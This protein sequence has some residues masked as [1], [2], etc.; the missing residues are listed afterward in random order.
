MR[1]GLI[2]LAVG[3]A[4]WFMPT[5]AGLKIQAWH[6]FV[7]FVTTIL[8]YILQPMPI[9]AIAFSAVTFSALSGTMKVANALSGY[10]NGTMWLIVSAF[11]F[12]RGFIKSGLGRRIAFI[13]IK[14]IGKSSLTLGYAITLSDFV[15]SPATPSSAARAGG[16]IFPIIKSLS[17]ALGSEPGQTARKFGAY[18][19]QVE[20]HANA[21]TC[22]MFMTAMAANPLMAE[23]ASQ[24]IGVQLTWASWA[25]AAIVPGSVS[26]LMPPNQKGQE[27]IT[28][29]I[30]S[31]IIGR[32]MDKGDV[33]S[34]W[35]EFIFMRQD[36]AEEKLQFG[37][38]SSEY[39]R[40]MEQVDALLE[41]QAGEESEASTLLMV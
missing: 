32:W 21:I 17:S 31:M 4:M 40:I 39:T 16:I 38:F 24:S 26:L 29:P 36:K 30:K 37:N 9:G 14:F 10:G 1:N 19:M 6:L 12:A 41:G 2:V 8:G 28:V 22:A 33:L 11:L 23:L 27:E 20:Y 13:I 5:P 3:V 18:I 7:I 35:Q 25:M 34:D 15:I